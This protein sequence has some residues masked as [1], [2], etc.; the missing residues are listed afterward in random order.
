MRSGNGRVA[1]GALFAWL[2]EMNEETEIVIEEVDVCQTWRA[3]EAKPSA[4]MIDV[5]SKAEWAF[6]GYPA[7]E[8]IGKSIIFLEWQTFPGNAKNMLFSHRLI[9]ELDA[10]GLGMET[11]LYFLC[12]T[13]VRS[14][15]AA[16]E[17]KQLGYSACF[18][19][20]KGFEGKLGDDKHR[21]AIDGWKAAELPWQQ[22]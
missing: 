15:K 16:R 21:G 1:S 12:R 10:R 4:Q 8:S 18:N 11:E 7:L 3:L 9:E 6:V 14:L 19:I 17:M 20:A 2:I 13:G 5:R 22:G